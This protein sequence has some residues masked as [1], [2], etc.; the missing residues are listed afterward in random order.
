MSDSLSHSDAAAG[1]LTFNVNG[2]SS[3]DGDSSGVL[4]FTVKLHSAVHPYRE[5][6]SILHTHTHT[7]THTFTL[8]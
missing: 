7:H 2:S 5:R 6:A 8:F 4:R 1:K 3:R